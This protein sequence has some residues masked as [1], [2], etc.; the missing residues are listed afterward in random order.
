MALKKVANMSVEEI[1]RELGERGHKKMGDRKAIAARLNAARRA[2]A[3][4]GSKRKSRSRKRKSKSR[5]RK[6]RSRKRKSKSGSR[7]RKSR[8]RS[9]RRC[10]KRNRIKGGCQFRGRSKKRAQIRAGVAY[11]SPHA[12]KVMRGKIMAA[13]GWTPPTISGRSLRSDFSRKSKFRSPVARKGPGKGRY[14]ASQ[15]DFATV[16]WGGKRGYI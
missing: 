11:R 6:S 5:K 16:F 10:S 14:R 7:K 12:A 15:G 4:A 3:R 13:G 1:R 8:S 9:R 2:G